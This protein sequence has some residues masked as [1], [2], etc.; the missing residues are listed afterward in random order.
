M[1]A[2]RNSMHL[3]FDLCDQVILDTESL[4]FSVTWPSPV[5]HTAQPTGQTLAVPLPT[6]YP[7]LM[8]CRQGLLC[9]SGSAFTSLKMVGVPQGLLP[10]SPRVWHSPGPSGLG[11]I[12]LAPLL[13]FSY[14]PITARP[15]LLFSFSVVGIEPKLLDVALSYI[16]SPFLF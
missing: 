15:L 8:W 7:T 2:T 12:H 16:H 13:S 10:F 4:D 9:S 14:S 6:G 1:K 11:H 3:L 5:N